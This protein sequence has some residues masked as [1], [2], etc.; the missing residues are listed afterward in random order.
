VLTRTGCCKLGHQTTEG[1]Q[2]D[3]IL[4]VR[5]DQAVKKRLEAH[6]KRLEKE[7]GINPITMSTVVRQFIQEGLTRAK[8]A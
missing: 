3:T 4:Y 8:P 1:I 6:A 7:T 2:M 5:I